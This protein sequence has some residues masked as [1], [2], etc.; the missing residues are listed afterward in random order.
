ML[1]ERPSLFTAVVSS[2]DSGTYHV[3]VDPL[4]TGKT[5]IL[6]GIPLAGMMAAALG[7]KECPTYSVGTAVLCAHLS[8]EVC[9]II[10]VIPEAD[11]GKLGAFNRTILKTFDAGYDEHNT[12]GYGKEAVKLRTHNAGRP[13]DLVEGELAFGNELGVL[14]GMFQ[15]F[16]ALKGSEL[17]QVQTFFLDDLVR[18]ISHNFQHWTSMGELNIFHDGK[19]LQLE[20]GATHLSP[21]SMGQPTLTSFGGTPIFTE[22]GPP[23]AS[24]ETDFFKLE[25]ERLKSIERLKCFIGRLGDFIHLYITRPAEEQR[26]LNGE[27]SGKYDTGLADVHVGTDGRISV[28]STTAIALEKTNWIRIPHRVR[29]P[30]DPEGD[31]GDTIEYEKK[32]PFEFDNQTK[33]RENPTAYFLQLRDCLAYLQDVSAYK[34][35]DKHEKDFK[36]SKSVDDN[37]EKLD[38]INTID[39]DTSANFADYKLRKSGLYLMDNGGVMLKDAWGSAIILDGGNIYLQPAKDLVQQPLRHMISKVGHSYSLAAKKNID[40]SSSEE[41]LRIKTTKQ[42]H[43]YSKDEGILIQSDATSLKE[44]A[45]QEEAYDEGGGVVIMAKDSAVVTYGKANYAYGSELLALKGKQEVYIEA[46]RTITLQSA[47]AINL[48]A[49]SDL[50]AVA[51]G[52]LTALADGNAMIGGAGATNVG[53][54]GSRIGMVPSPGSQFPCSMDGVL[55]VDTLVSSYDSIINSNKDTKLIAVRPYD[56]ESSFESVKFRFL[57][58]DKYNLDEDGEF[59]PMTISQ[60]D[61]DAFGK[62]NLTDWIEEEQESTLPFPGKDK[63]ED[64]YLK[65]KMQNGQLNGEDIVTKQIDGVESSAKLEKASLQEYKV[66]NAE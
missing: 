59:I 37:E 1:S 34:N 36:T 33:Y 14:L 45:P 26:E 38:N 6:Q 47:Q 18:I 13:T 4:A 32:D 41:G 42:Q 64:F 56:E 46:D 20:Y 51:K 27:L 62:L 5:G 31:D 11:I 60:Q 8:G 19:S 61:E 52:N 24:D 22:E 12:L 10:G 40:L 21:E 16:M 9:Y 49:T 48:F 25:K 30:E 28:R 3:S 50:L 17:A 54:E 55:P 53:K 35:F 57:A 44:L 63:F 29:S 65:S 43:Y 23:E 58:S 39:P 7:F 15:Q 2:F 66:F